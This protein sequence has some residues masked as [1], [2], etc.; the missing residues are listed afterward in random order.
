MQTCNASYIT[1]TDHD[2]AL[3]DARQSHTHSDLTHSL[4][5]ST[6]SATYVPMGGPAAT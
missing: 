2:K 1:E 4:I 6:W 3:H 5:H